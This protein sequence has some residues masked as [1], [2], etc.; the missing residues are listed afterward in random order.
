MIL[1]ISC[2]DQKGLV[3]KITGV[4]Y[5]YGLNVLQ[6]DEYVDKNLNRFYM[7]TAFNSKVN[8]DELMK[9]VKA[10]LPEDAYCELLGSQPQKLVLMAS[11]EYHCLSD[12][13]VRAES[14]DL[15]AEIQC[16]VSNHKVLLDFAE[17]F[18]IPYYYVDHKDITREAHENKIIDII[19]Q[20]SHDYI[21]LAKY[22]R[23]LTPN[24]IHTFN[25]KLINIHHSFLPAFK[26]ARPYQQA[27]ERGVKI[28]G[29]TAHF[30][31]EDLD[32]GPIIEQDIVKVN[33][34]YSA[35]E[36]ARF[37]KDVEKIVLARALNLVLE[38]RV[39]INGNKTIVF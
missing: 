1:K 27:Y 18:D 19:K 24:F 6:N 25:K 34:G 12:I 3:H 7:R 26:G 17:K 14:K 29:A 10:L 13:I 35:K 9:E 37:G 33:H 20:Y 4:L 5:R 23:V 32:E 21:V 11:K 15:N 31:N 39:F 16:V 38:H 36:M 30:V 2:E 22:M 28:I 8:K